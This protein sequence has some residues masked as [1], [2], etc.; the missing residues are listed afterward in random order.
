MLEVY[1]RLSVELE[2]KRM[3]IYN[4]KEDR[5][6]ESLYSDEE[7]EI[8]LNCFKIYFDRLKLEGVCYILLLLKIKDV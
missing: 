8:F 6:D 2:E 3:E 4:N 5:I 7:W 1:I